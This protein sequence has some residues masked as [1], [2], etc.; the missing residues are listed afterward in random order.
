VAHLQDVQIG[1]QSIERYRALVGDARIDACLAAA[2]EARSRL[3]GRA[4]WNINSTA[5]GG[6]VAEMLR[7]V[8]AYV[9]GMG[10]DVRW[11]VVNGA[12]EF[13]QLTKRLHHA[14]HGSLGDGSPI[15][16][17]R[18]PTYEQ[19]IEANARELLAVLD[20]ADIVIL[21]DP[22]TAGLLPHLA[23]LGVC[24][25]WHCHIGHDS[26]NEEAEAGWNFL[27]PY[28][29][30][31]ARLVFT[32]E[33]YVPPGVDRAKTVVIPP[34][35]DAFAAKNQDMAPETV[36]AILV[37]AGI[38]EGPLGEGARMFTREDGSPGRVDRCADIV[39]TGRSPTIDTPL[40]VQVSRWDPLKDHLGV[41]HGF[42]A[43]A[44]QARCG[45]AH[46][47]LAGPN[48]SAVSDDPEGADTLHRV[49]DAW[50]ELPH[51][52]RHRVQ[53][54]SLPMADAEE[55]AAMVN[56]LQRHASIIVQKSLREGFGLTVTEAMW[57]ARPLIASRVGGIQDQA[58]H[59]V[60]A[61]L[62]DDP[63]NIHEFGET[64]CRLLTDPAL[65]ERLGRNARKRVEDQYLVLRLLSQYHDLLASLPA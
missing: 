9:R 23:R 2:G 14:L 31:A 62:V 11:Q 59:E 37:H 64:L 24:T 3:Q 55:N 50:R 48:V 22:Q 35:I 45:E 1:T 58:R 43:V 27:Y 13:F 29:D 52:V 63:A 30:H 33:S 12:P 5:R 54:A 28:L 18:R 38:V 8:L 44:G 65:G 16:E 51:G 6:G 47:V 32:R 61:L 25:V 10:L 20:P 19:S 49:I 41:M 4:I 46:L 36:Q 53:I 26:F 21:H 15:D 56:A 57:K 7:P 60:E 17:S 42:A 34:A 39:H 40:V